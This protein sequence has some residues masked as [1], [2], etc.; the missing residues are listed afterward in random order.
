M[1]HTELGAARIAVLEQ[2]QR[3]LVWQFR[4]LLIAVFL[5]ACLAFWQQ[6]H[7]RW[8]L[9]QQEGLVNLLQQMELFREPAVHREP[10]TTL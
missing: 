9:T 8:L 6:L 4:W 1:P 3:R 7:N 2:R 5:L 10:P